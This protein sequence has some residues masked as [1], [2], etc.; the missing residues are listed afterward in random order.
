MP[1]VDDGSAAYICRQCKLTLTRGPR[2]AHRFEAECMACDP[3]YRRKL[4]CRSCDQ[5]CKRDKFARD[6]EKISEDGM[7]R[8]APGRLPDRTSAEI[9]FT[10][11]SFVGLHFLFSDS[12]V[13]RSKVVIILVET[14]KFRF[15]LDFF[16]SYFI[17]SIF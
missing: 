12:R 13:V 1:S 14:K 10:F 6:H 5:F 15:F 3:R 11:R 2:P 17:Y 9:K 8:C 7:T 16:T 4:F